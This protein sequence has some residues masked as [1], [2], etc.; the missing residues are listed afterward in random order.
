MDVLPKTRK[1]LKRIIEG[2]QTSKST[3][4]KL[5]NRYK[6]KGY[7][8]SFQEDEESHRGSTSLQTSH[9]NLGRN[10][11]HVSQRSR[12]SRRQTRGR[13]RT[14]RNKVGNRR[15]R[16]VRRYFINPYNP[17]K[18]PNYKTSV[19][20]RR[21]IEQKLSKN[22]QHSMHSKM[23]NDMRL[24]LQRGQ[25]G[26]TRQKGY[27]A[28]MT[29]RAPMTRPSGQDSIRMVGSE[30]LKTVKVVSRQG[31]NP[32]VAGNIISI[33]HM[34]PLMLSGTRLAQVASTYQKYKYQNVT[35][36]FIP[37]ISSLQDGSLI[38]FV[39]YEPAENYTISTSNED[40][41]LRLAFSHKGANSFNVYDYG[42]CT[43]TKVPDSL[44]WYFTNIVDTDPEEQEQGAFYVVASSSYTNVVEE[45]ELTLG[46]IF[47][48]YDV[49]LSTR[50]I[51]D[52]VSTSESWNTQ[53]TT[54]ATA[55]LQ[56][57]TGDLPLQFKWAPFQNGQLPKL[58]FIYIIYAMVDFDYNSNGPI[59]I[60][61]EKGEQIFATKGSIWYGRATDEGTDGTDGPITIYPDYRS[62][63]FDEQTLAV[64][65]G[66]TLTGTNSVAWNFNVEAI[67]VGFED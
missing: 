54:T 44:K 12:Y 57:L 2:D 46:R 28:P 63:L 18:R 31:Q 26:V 33:T 40:E 15:N 48:H 45:G 17:G 6:R 56:N 20:V 38:M 1:T 13:V 59:Q 9:K 55:L 3:K 66:Q 19:Q 67:Q 61:D 37:S 21:N 47:I 25:V 11:R 23:L 29:F 42:R 10:P 58:N 8:E 53:S 60:Y 32:T 7:E 64:R 49:H 52:P 35:F 22:T 24:K 16:R 4:S 14:H 34:S 39:S 5:N 30:Y 36:E 27:L 65:L 62:A 43:L 41:L 50:A 51:T